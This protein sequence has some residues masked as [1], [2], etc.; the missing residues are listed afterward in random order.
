MLESLLAVFAIWQMWKGY[1]V[2]GE[3]LGLLAATAHNF[4]ICQ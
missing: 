4:P 3:H 1:W 2:V